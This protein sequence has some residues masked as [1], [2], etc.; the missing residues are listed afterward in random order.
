MSICQQNAIFTVIKSVC[1]ST[2]LLGSLQMMTG[3]D[4]PNAS[5]KNT[6]TSKSDAA[7]KSTI[8]RDKAASKPLS[9]ITSTIDDKLPKLSDDKMV[10]PS[11]YQILS[12]GQTITP[13]IL[14]AGE[15]TKE[16]SD[17]EQCYYVSDPKRSYIDDNYGKR[18]SVLYQIIDD[19]VALITIQDPTVL[20]YT[21]IKVGDAVEDVMK[22]HDDNL[23]YEVDKYAADGEYYN[24]I[25]N[26]NFT[27]VGRNESGSP[28]KS[29][30]IKLN[31]EADK[32]P[33]Q[34]KYHM[35]GGQKL[36]S[37]QIKANEWTAENKGMLKGQVENID[38][39]IPEAIYLVEG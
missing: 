14:A 11:G 29:A 16:G 23:I 36:N 39:G 8:A 30:S 20:F 32:L 3:C 25:A 9:P 33:L 37:Y 13:D 6:S 12:F 26:V 19:K 10:S 4:L 27:V 7:D 1:F 24:L 28:L 15:L 18:A 21:G 38:M 31:N 34:I 17:N 22:M 5:S 35:K 2:V